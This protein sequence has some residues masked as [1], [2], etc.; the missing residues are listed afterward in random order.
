MTGRQQEITALAT[1]LGGLSWSWEP[2]EV[3]QVARR[4]G[5]TDVEEKDLEV[6]FRVDGRKGFA[7]KS[8]DGAVER[9]YIPVF[10]AG[11]RGPNAVRDAFAEIVALTTEALGEPAARVHA[12]DPEV[13]WRGE[14]DAIVL[15][16]A[17]LGQA[18]GVGFGLHRDRGAADASPAALPRSFTGPEIVDVARGLLSLE[19]P[20]D[21]AEA[22]RLIERLGW[23]T[24][25]S[26]RGGRL[27]DT[28]L[29]SRRAWLRFRR[30]RVQEISVD[31][32]TSL[33]EHDATHR[34]LLHDVFATAAE[35]LTGE[36]GRRV[37]RDPGPVASLVWN[38]GGTTVRLGRQPFGAVLHV[39]AER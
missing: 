30:D 32:C 31:L 12:T 13:H 11:D 17:A 29:G 14:G 27:L 33:D 39:S 18:R 9:L 24:A 3:A 20:G 15:V 10:D 26:Y 5:W 22:D 19:W 23:R 38:R 7:E 16:H 1:G 6:L 28:P 34:A 25:L 21:P 36:L 37:R 8:P 2:A 4:F 35:A